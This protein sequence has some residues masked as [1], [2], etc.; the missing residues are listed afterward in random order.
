MMRNTPDYLDLEW[1]SGVIT[2]KVDVSSF[3]IVILKILSGRR[4]FEAS[5]TEEDRIMLN[6]FRK[7]QRK[8][9]W[10]ILLISIVKICS[11]TKKK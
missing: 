1:L 6:L 3:G 5:E 9:S 8:G 2:E 7:T 11:S 10:W 4:H